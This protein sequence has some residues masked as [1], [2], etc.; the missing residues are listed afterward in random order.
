MFFKMIATGR[1]PTGTAG[2]VRV[3]RR[4]RRSGLGGG[5]S[6]GSTRPPRHSPAAAHNAAQ[7]ASSL[8]RTPPLAVVRLLSRHAIGLDDV[9]LCCETDID[10]SGNYRPLW[11]VVTKDRALVCSDADVSSLESSLNFC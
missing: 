2:P 1:P 7:P 9:L 4:P 6:P 10:A 11:L 5:S 3:R 8:K